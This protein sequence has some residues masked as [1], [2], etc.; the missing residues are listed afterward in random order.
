[1]QDNLN[2][3][4]A[5]EKWTTGISKNGKQIDWR[6]SIRQEI[7]E[8]IDSFPWKHWAKV[9]DEIDWKNAKIEIVDVWHFLLSHIIATNSVS[10]TQ[11]DGYVCMIFSIYERKPTKVDMHEIIELAE[12][13]SISTHDSSPI[14][15]MEK[16]FFLCYVVGLDFEALIKLYIGK[17]ALNKLRQDNGYKEGTY[18]K[19]WNGL[20]DN[21]V[22]VE[23]VEK[24][25]GIK[26]INEIYQQLEEI[27]RSLEH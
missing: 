22:M 21:K 10:T 6:R 13:F 19:H 27:Y 26:K 8:F 24:T 3:S 25:N 15:L 7:S 5:G 1:M 4:T 14:A 11:I 9:D 2:I 20:E 23:V 17:N 16:F 18:K 12:D